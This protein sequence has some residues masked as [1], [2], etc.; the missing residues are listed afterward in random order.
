MATANQRLSQTSRQTKS[1][2]LFSNLFFFLPS[3]NRRVIIGVEEIRERRK[4][5][6]IIKYYLSCYKK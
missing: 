6:F 2:V 4:N 1:S 3:Y 5:Y